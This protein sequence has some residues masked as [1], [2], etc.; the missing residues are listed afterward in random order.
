[1]NKEKINLEK[2]DNQ[3]LSKLKTISRY[4]QRYELL[5]KIR[6]EEVRRGIT[7]TYAKRYSVSINNEINNR[8][9]FETD[10]YTEIISYYKKAN[11]IL[12]K[13]RDYYQGRFFTNKHRNIQLNEIKIQINKLIV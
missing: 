12:S 7:I 6:T 4:A 2:L 1:M 5:A 8:V 3:E 10:N 11:L 9:I 13:W